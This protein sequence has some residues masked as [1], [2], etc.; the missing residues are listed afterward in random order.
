MRLASRRILLI[1]AGHT[2]L[3]IVRMWMQQPI[4]GRIAAIH[5]L[6]DLWGS[7]LQS[8]SALAIVG[9]VTDVAGNDAKFGHPII[10][11]ATSTSFR[12]P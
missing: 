12:S 11:I 7:G 9:Q 6:S 4:A 1:G 3:H 8:A 2:N 5:A 10:K